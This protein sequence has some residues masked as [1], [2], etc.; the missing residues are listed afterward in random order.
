MTE[1]IDKDELDKFNSDLSIIRDGTKHVHTFKTS[2]ER[3]DNKKCSVEINARK[4]N[5]NSKPKILM[6]MRDVTQIVSK[7][8]L[9]KLKNEALQESEKRYRSLIRNVENYAIFLVNHDG[10]ITSWNTGAEIVLGYK[11]HEI[12]RKKFSALFPRERRDFG[13]PVDLLNKAGKDAH[14]ETDTYL[15]K[16]NGERLWASIT[17]TRI[18]N[19]KLN[20]VDF[21]III[22]DLTENK[23]A[24]DRMHEQEV[25]LRAL[26]K[27]LQDAREEERLRIARELH[28]EFSQML[29]VLRMELTVLSSTIS[30]T[31]KEPYK[32]ISLLDKISSIS[33]L[34]ENTI[35]STRRIIAE[36]RPAV[37]DELGLNTAIQ[38]QTQEFEN[39]TSIRCKIAKL[40]PD[41]ELDKQ[42]STAIFRI[43]QEGLTNVAKHARATN[44]IISLSVENEKLLLE[45]KDNGKGIDQ[46]K[47]KSPTST[48]LLGIRERV[49]ALNGN[50]EIHSEENSGTRLLISIPY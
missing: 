2:I 15:V 45:I 7:N 24:E 25:Q 28:D 19:G 18:D 34:L 35:R 48:G 23:L 17:I 13:K 29:T 22:R 30:K 4:M 31:V 32:R 6:I 49:V 44:V 20:H 8:L 16:K 21:S 37:L 46:M 50:F 33:E 38:W 9:G 43:L 14:F 12:F 1:F 41:I 10:I 3:K 39:R 42:T 40:E 47:L 5:I 36:L 26:A 11:E 27:H